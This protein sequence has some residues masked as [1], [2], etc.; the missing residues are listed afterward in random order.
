MAT[1]T[2]K[3]VFNPFTDNFDQVIDTTMIPSLLETG[4]V[5][6]R[7]GNIAIFGQNGKLADSGY[8]LNEAGEIVP[9]Q[10]GYFA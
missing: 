4:P 8:Y 3:Y 6:P 1:P 2:Y 7:E 10:G 9:A 5:P